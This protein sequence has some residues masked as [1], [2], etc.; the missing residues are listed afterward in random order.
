MHCNISLTILTAV[1]KQ[2]HC[3][4]SPKDYNCNLYTHENACLLF[5][6]VKTAGDIFIEATNKDKQ[7]SPLPHLNPANLNSQGKCKII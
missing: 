6:A 4:S 1:S 5:H 2:L 7:F 3:W